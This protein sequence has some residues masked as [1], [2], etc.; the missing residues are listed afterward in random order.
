M[1][2]A[3]KARLDAARRWLAQLVLPLGVAGALLAGVVA[4]GR[5][6]GERGAVVHF[7]DLECDPPEGMTRQ[8]F[9]EE[10][11]YLS[12]VPNQLGGPN[13]LAQVQE[14]LAKHP[15]VLR[16]TRVQ[17]LPGGRA[18][19]ELEYRRPAL[20]V[21]RPPREVDAEGVLLPRSGGRKGLPLLTTKVAPPVGKPGRP[22]GDVRVAAAA[23][24]VAL[25]R[26][27]LGMGGGTVEVE[28]GEVTIRAGK[29][30]LLWGRPPGY[31]KPGEASTAE[32]LRRLPAEAALQGREC[33]LRPAAGARE[34]AWAP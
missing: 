17:R 4:L 31:E 24:V 11:E 1:T 19:A 6:L 7:R 3:R 10:A 20:A 33:D 2:E 26:P 32:K 12:D 14:A 21:E 15:W 16:V 9:L 8:Q 5:H 30:R 34:R 18:R 23:Q 22:W 25:L 28:E 27:R 29:Y 13:A